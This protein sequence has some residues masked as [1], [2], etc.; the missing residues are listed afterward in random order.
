MTDSSSSSRGPDLGAGAIDTGTA[1]AAR[2]Y[3]YMIGG[4]THFAADRE[5]SHA[6]AALVPG[7]HEAA[8]AGLIA[9]RAFLGRA[10]RHLAAEAGIRQFLDIGTGIPTGDN[11]HEVA[12]RVAPESRIVYVDYDPIV[13]AHSHQ[14]LTSS[15]EGETVY[16]QADLRDPRAILDQ[17]TAVLDFT[18]PIA[19][20]LVA[21]L[22]FL[23]DD[24]NPYGIVTELLDALPPGS[25]M[26]L[27]H[28]ASDIYDLDATYE[29][30]NQA[31]QET[32]VLRS[33]SEVSRFFDGLEM[34]DPG[35]VLVDR[36]RPDPGHTPHDGIMLPLY[37]GVGRK[38]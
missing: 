20:V 38:P 14:L 36:W 5:A 4:R 11:V 15:D 17:A 1:H 33:H 19:L 23:P 3:D 8:S 2:I 25:Y 30:L 6:A 22:H 7:G 26:V 32:F 35:V 21:I 18:R 29:R 13:L 27:S 16:L 12:Q 9:N 24:E 37:G 28:L 31:T 10:V 34:V